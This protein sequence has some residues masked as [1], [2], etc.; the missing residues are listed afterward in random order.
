MNVKLEMNYDVLSDV[1]LTLQQEMLGAS[2]RHDGHY[3]CVEIEREA[4]LDERADVDEPLLKLL[5]E[6]IAGG[7][8]VAFDTSWDP[9]PDGGVLA[10][11]MVLH[12][13]G[14]YRDEGL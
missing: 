7:C 8:D 3:L 2:A 9:D 4:V 6:R 14:Q 12:R 11:E 5:Q 13:F 1:L 10:M